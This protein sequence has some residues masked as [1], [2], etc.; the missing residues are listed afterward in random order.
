MSEEEEVHRKL[1]EGLIKQR[2]PLHQ[3]RDKVFKLL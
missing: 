1:N 3:E 2:R